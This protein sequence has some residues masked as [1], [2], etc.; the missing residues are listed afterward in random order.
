MKKSTISALGVLAGVGAVLAMGAPAAAADH[1]F[2]LATGGAAAYGTYDRMM[3][4]PERPVPPIRVQGTLALNGRNRCAVVQIA[5]N[6]PADGIEWRTLNSLCQP[7]KTNFSA[8]SDYL[9]GGFEPGLRLCVG[10]TVQRAEQG[11]DCD[12]HTPAATS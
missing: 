8:A 9:W 11:R 3:S 5:A 12:V 6:G 4:I 2:D 1:T 7:G 10:A